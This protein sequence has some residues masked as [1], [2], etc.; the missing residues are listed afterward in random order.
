MLNIF[1]KPEN[2]KNKSP[3]KNCK[4]RYLHCH[5]D[6]IKYN[7][8]IIDIHN[9]KKEIKLKRNNDNVVLYDYMF[10]KYKKGKR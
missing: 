9:E 8:Y 6:C 2:Y 4:V 3:C 5:A 1:N 10:K 7:K